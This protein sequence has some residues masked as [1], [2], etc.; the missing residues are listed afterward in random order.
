M[1]L[2][3]GTLSLAIHSYSETYNHIATVPKEV[4]G[5]SPVNLL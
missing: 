2:K 3:S 4:H 1:G 5:L